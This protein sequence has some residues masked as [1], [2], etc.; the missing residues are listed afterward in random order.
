MRNIL[1]KIRA[2]GSLF[3]LVLRRDGLLVL[4]R[5]VFEKIY[6]RIVRC[7]ETVEEYF[8]RRDL[9]RAVFSGPV[10]K[11]KK[12]IKKTVDIIVCVHNALE[13][14]ERCLESVYRYSGNKFSLIVVDD[15]SADDTRDFLLEFSKSHK[16][17]LLRN[18]QAL[19]Y[20]FAANIGLKNSSADYVVLLNSD[21][22]VTEDWLQ[23]MMRCGESDQK[24]GIVGPLSNTASW[25]SVPKIL[26][27]GDWAENKFPQGVALEKW[28][29]LITQH[30]G[31]VYPKIPF[32]NGF[33]LMLKRSLIEDLGY[34]DEESFGR[35]YGEENDYCLRAGKR[36]WLLAVADDVY[37][38]HAQSK[39][40]SNDK[41][42]TL[43]EIAG[44]ILEEKH[45]KDL[46][47]QGVDECQ[48]SILMEGVRLRIDFLHKNAT[49][50]AGVPAFDVDL[51]MPRRAMVN[52]RKK[53]PLVLVF[54][55]NESAIGGKSSLVEEM[56]RN[57]RYSADAIAFGRVLDDVQR[58]RLFN[59]ADIL[60]NFSDSKDDDVVTLEA[61]ASGVAVIVAN[62][63][64][65]DS[66]FENGK[67]CLIA[68]PGNFSVTKDVIGRLIADNGLRNEIVINGLRSVFAGS[69]KL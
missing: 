48:K 34:F 23:R 41:R 10:R 45:G 69:R 66:M 1:K 12:E 5:R 59:E 62:C 29:A 8:D 32:L 39:S 30:S 18:E 42:K 44:K 43:S 6:S 15:G 47:M 53:V 46:I 40:Y 64:T 60:I 17:K 11:K 22:I 26:E 67:N 57:F 38:F 52:R 14:V 16:I 13:D 49:G 21:T 2:K 58:A 24:V 56:R 3:L 36:G 7:R 28:G 37:V 68:D 19:G 4:F 35:G 65:A 51:F 31:R 9:K 63:N 54:K 27:N 61:M 25:Q 33:C 55:A 20:T 50:N